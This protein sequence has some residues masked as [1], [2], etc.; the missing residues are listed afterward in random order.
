[1]SLLPQHSGRLLAALAFITCAAIAPSAQ[2]PAPAEPAQAPQPPTFRLEANFVR[3]DVYPTA[4][5]VPVTDLTKADFEVLEDG[6][7]Q[8]IETFEHVEIPRLTPIE[9]QQDPDSV[10]AMRAQAENPRARVFVIFLDTY[11]TDVAGSHRMQRSLVTM[12]DRMLSADDLFAV[13]T[14]Q[15]SPSDLAFARKSV[16]VEGYLRRHWTWG[17]RDRM[18]PEDPVE[19]Q[20]I[21]CYPSSN[22]RYPISE[23]ADELIHRRREKFVL[24]ALEDLSLYLRGVREERKAVITVS[25]GWLLP[26]ERRELSGPGPRPGTLGTTPGGRITADRM[27]AEYGFSDADCARD[28]QVLMNADLWQEYQDL[29]DVANRANVTFYPV[30]S[31]GLSASD[32]PLNPLKP[33][34]TPA[35]EI[36]LVRARV[37]SLQTLAVN[38]DGLAVINT[39]DIDGGLKRIVADMTSYYLVGYYS[40]NTKLDGRFRKITVRV[41]RPGVEVRARRGYKA[42][43]AEELRPSSTTTATPAGPPA[44]LQRALAALA[45]ARPATIRSA[46]SLSHNGGNGRTSR[47]AW[48][49]VELDARSA[50]AEFARGGDIAVVAAAADGS[51]LAQQRGTMAPGTRA[52]I[53]DLGALATAGGDLVVRSRVRPDGDGAP[54]SDTVSIAADAAGGPSPVLWRRGPSTGMRDVVTAD[55][56]FTRGDRV[57][58]EVALEDASTPISARLLDRAGGELAVPV[59]VSNRS[60]RGAVWA[61]AELALA[62]LAP[63][64]YVLMMTIGGPGES[65]DIYTGIRVVP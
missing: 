55:A 25:N 52:A 30:D 22:A 37:E 43:T 34:K 16:T 62:P 60:E 3:V 49:T 54:L 58:A 14:P 10:A 61:T 13:M 20:Y 47:R 65:V 28:R 45:S 56:R 11:H 48:A 23:L 9:Q 27:K 64:D 46:V 39:N 50:K 24:D 40:K 4:D 18:L 29:M 36:A 63:G 21:L 32:S 42:A 26:R 38:T 51:V 1:M 6:E 41:K 33:E 31:R 19:R 8:E 35:E 44:G 15:M 7:P 53:V 59:T 17:T 2:A 5:G 57:R 12:L